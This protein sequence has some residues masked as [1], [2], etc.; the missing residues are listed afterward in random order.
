MLYLGK[1]R[2]QRTEP[3]R[4]GRP[5]VTSRRLRPVPTLGPAHAPQ[6]PH[7]LATLRLPFIPLCSDLHDGSPSSSPPPPLPLLPFLVL[8]LAFSHSWA[9]RL[10]LALAPGATALP[11]RWR[12]LPGL[13]A[14][15]LERPLQAGSACTPG[16]SGG[17]KG[18]QARYNGL[19][20][21]MRRKPPRHRTT[22]TTA[23]ENR[24]AEAAVA[25]VLV[26]VLPWRMQPGQ[27]LVRRRLHRQRVRLAFLRRVRAAVA[28]PPGQP[29]WLALPRRT[30]VGP[31]CHMT[32][33]LWPGRWLRCPQGGL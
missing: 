4:R 2:K 22:A 3:R 6:P 21:P 33:R 29:S 20:G 13:K 25:W 28:G 32:A 11:S 18:L 26:R 23:T 10:V 31:S 1:L 12:S 15:A 8:V 9:G 16:L 7:H 14:P 5:A 19:A 17:R 24:A 27:Q 30:P